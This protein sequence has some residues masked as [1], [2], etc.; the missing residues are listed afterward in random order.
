MWKFRSV[1]SELAVWFREQNN[2]IKVWELEKYTN[3][4]FGHFTTISGHFFCHLHIYLSQNLGADD[5][6][7]GL[8]VSKS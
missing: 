8:N 7:E 1:V 2:Q 4:M 6:F 5:H 3:F